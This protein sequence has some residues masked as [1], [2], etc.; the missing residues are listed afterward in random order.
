[1]IIAALIGRLSLG[2]YGHTHNVHY[3]VAN[4]PEQNPHDEYLPFLA[5]NYWSPESLHLTYHKHLMLFI[6]MAKQ[7]APYWVYL[8]YFTL[9]LRT[10]I[11]TCNH[12]SFSSTARDHARSWPG[13]NGTLRLLLILFTHCFNTGL[14]T[15][16]FAA[17]IRNMYL[18]YSD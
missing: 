13:G 16:L 18:L 2:W 10:L 3:L 14:S 8:Y 7:I 15:V 12:G 6:D 1:M 5:V 9:I 11:C 4:L 17:L